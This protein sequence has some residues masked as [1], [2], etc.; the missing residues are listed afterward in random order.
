[1][2]GDVEGEQYREQLMVKGAQPTALKQPV[3]CSLEHTEV[4]ESLWAQTFKAFTT[5][6]VKATMVIRRKNFMVYENGGRSH[7]QDFDQTKS[8]RSNCT[9]TSFVL[10]S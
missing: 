8:R 9:V 4:G 1:L 3:H 6:L 5:L 7:E 2:G 10:L